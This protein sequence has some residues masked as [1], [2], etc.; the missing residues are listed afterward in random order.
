MNPERIGSYFALA[1]VELCPSGRSR[2]EIDAGGGIM[3]FLVVRK[4]CPQTPQGSLKEGDI[5]S[6][7]RYY[8]QK[9]G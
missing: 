1:P 7:D 9:L 6:V 5:F 8:L 4:A 2:S 3:I